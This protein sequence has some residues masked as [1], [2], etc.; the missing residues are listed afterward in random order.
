MMEEQ[1]KNEDRSDLYRVDQYYKTI[2]T[3]IRSIAVIAVAYFAFECFRQFAGKSTELNLALSLLVNA[4]V[5]IK[6][7]VSLSVAGLASILAWRERRLRY[8]KTE[9]LQGRIIK[10]ERRIDPNRSSSGL[11]PK[12]KTNPMDIER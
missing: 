1:Q 3:G 2:R 7:V 5:D 8:R 4:L 12:G 9:E 11:T 6:F 10:L